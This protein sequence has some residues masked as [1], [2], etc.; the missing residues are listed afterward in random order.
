MNKAQRWSLIIYIAG[1]NAIGDKLLTEWRFWP[2]L[3][4][5]MISAAM[6]AKEP[7]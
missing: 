6:F 7:E 3:V 2:L 5:T 4:L 1:I